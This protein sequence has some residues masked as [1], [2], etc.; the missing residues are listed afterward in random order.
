MRIIKA[1]LKINPNANVSVSGDDINTAVIKWHGSTTPISKTDIENQLDT[2]DF[3]NALENL[4][5][6]RNLLLAETD[7]FGNSDVT[8]SDDMTTYRQNLRD[9]TNGLTTEADVDAVVFPTKPSE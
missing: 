6:K 8:M 3:E 4:R 9:L 7:Y 1:I 5:N 2:V